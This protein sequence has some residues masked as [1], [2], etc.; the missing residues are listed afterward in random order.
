[1]SAL[2]VDTIVITCTL[3]HNTC[4]SL[5]IGTHVNKHAYMY[6]YICAYSEI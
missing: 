3:F 1:M 2:G 5:F 6:M 4:L